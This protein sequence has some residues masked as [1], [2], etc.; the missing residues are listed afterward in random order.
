MPPTI[1]L[2]ESEHVIGS[3]KA[4]HVDGSIVGM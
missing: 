2:M 3:G 1:L 4:G